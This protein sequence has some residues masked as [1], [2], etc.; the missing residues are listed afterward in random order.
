MPH[1][2]HSECSSFPCVRV[3]R[4][5]DLVGICSCISSAV[6]CECLVAAKAGN[7]AFLHIEAAR[8]HEAATLIAPTMFL[9]QTSQN[10]P[11]LGPGCA[12]PSLA[13]YVPDRPDASAK[14]SLQQPLAGGAPFLVDPQVAAA[15]L[16]GGDPRK[17]TTYA[18]QSHQDAWTQHSLVIRVSVLSQTS[19]YMRICRRR[20]I[21]CVQ[22]S[23]CD[24]NIGAGYHLQR[25]SHD[26]G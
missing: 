12:G 5:I 22:D 23:L 25:W 6:F 4:G 24:R 3:L 20:C 8:R 2:H 13:Q 11:A 7:P 10:P 9:G 18:L 15:S 21:L 19:V 16:S 17:H 26:S 14:P 1:A